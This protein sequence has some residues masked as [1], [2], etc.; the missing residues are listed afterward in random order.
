MPINFSGETPKGC[1]KVLSYNTWNFGAQTEDA[2][3]TNI[4]IPLILQEQDA[5]IVCLQEACPTSR[6]IEQI[7]SM[8][9]PMYAYQDTTMHVNGGNCLM[10][11]SKYPILSKS[12]F[13]M[14]RKEIC[15]AAYR[16]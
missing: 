13:L 1:I 10:L 14:N 7:D 9:K 11:L 15:S 16:L 12:E 5:D 4:C 3:G 2:E 8:L 6:N